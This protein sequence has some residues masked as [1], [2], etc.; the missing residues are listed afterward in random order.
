[1]KEAKNE[2]LQFVAG[3][4]ML[5]VGLYI[6]SQ[7]VMVSSTY[8]FFSLWG[9]TFSSGLIMI[10]FIIGVVWM[11]ATGGSFASKVF[12]ALSVL[13]IIV[14]IIVSTRIWLVRITMYEWVL[15]LVLIFGGAG[16]VAK[17]LFA[18]NKSERESGKKDKDNADNFKKQADSIDDEIERMKKNM[19]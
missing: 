5:V 2:L 16:L 11:F 4:I 7:K 9:G 1:M 10:P 14:S 19:K 15:I 12:T 8:G 18:N 6:L 17:V 3:V 13:L